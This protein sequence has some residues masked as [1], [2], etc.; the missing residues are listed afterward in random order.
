MKGGSQQLPVASA[1]RAVMVSGHLTDVD[2][3][4]AP[5]FPESEVARVKDEIVRRFVQWGV[6]TDDVVLCG[7]ARGADLLAAEA[8]LECNAQVRLLLA[9]PREKFALTSV[10]PDDSPWRKRFRLV[11][12]RAQIEV[13]PAL[14]DRSHEAAFEETNHWLIE[15]TMEESTDRFALL[16]WDGDS[17]AKGG[18]AHA[19]R[20]ALEN[21]FT[22]AR[23]AP[24][25]DNGD[26]APRE[27]GVRATHTEIDQL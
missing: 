1:R 27:G 12:N 23:I 24:L 6:G 21:G 26:A 9:L 18:T 5:R 10:G 2:D 14:R 11:A 25:P 16:V 17:G 13:L 15:Q 20:L 3:R 8:A 4:A 22:I 19:A 7:G